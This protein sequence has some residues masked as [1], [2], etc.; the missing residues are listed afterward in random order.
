MN[1]YKYKDS[2]YVNVCNTFTNTNTVTLTVNP[3]PVIVLSANPFTKLYPG[4]TTTLSA[5]VSPNPGATYTWYRNGMIVPG[6]TANTLVV[7]IDGLGVYTVNVNDV[8]GCNSTSS[9]IEIKEDANDILFIYPSPNTG[10]FQVRYYSL[11][12]NNPL[13]RIINVFDSKGTRIF[14]KTYSINVPYSRLD[15]SLKNHGKGIYSV[16]LSDANGRRL[17][18]GRVVIL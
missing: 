16:E 4:V 17:K 11:G 3:N 18:T 8:N 13:P 15:V 12:G 10:Q 9:A 14:S 2:L 6:A 1:G 5:A 7:D